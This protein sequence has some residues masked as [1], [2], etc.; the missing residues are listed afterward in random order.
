METLWHLY[1]MYRT[2][3][4]TL[5]QVPAELIWSERADVKPM[6]RG[7]VGVE[8]FEAHGVRSAWIFDP[9]QD[10]HGSYSGY[11]YKGVGNSDGSPMY[12]RPSG[13]YRIIVGGQ[14]F[15]WAEEEFTTNRALWDAGVACQRPIALFRLALE[16][17]ESSAG[18][19][20]RT[21]RSP[22]RLI[23][24][25]RQPGL[26]DRYLSITREDLQTYAGRLGGIIGR[27]LVRMFNAAMAKPVDIDNTSSEGELLDFEHVWNGWFW[28]SPLQPC[29]MFEA[30]YPIFREF[31]FSLASGTADFER[32]FVED[33]C[34]GESVAGNP[35]EKTRQ[36]IGRFLGLDLTDDQLL[37]PVNQEVRVK[38]LED[39]A[40]A[41]AFYRELETNRAAW[42][43]IAEGEFLFRNLD[44]LIQITEDDMDRMRRRA[45]KAVMP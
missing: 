16:G 42:T 18:L 10:S 26:L 2:G 29:Y 13:P 21:S 12:E 30:I 9:W 33:F 1:R 31:G 11:E 45:P 37:A 3:L 35:N 14:R 28:G 22:I 19:L 24:F 17:I 23:D 15:D 34:G 27:S 43:K 25:W 44:A 38:L 40:R 6:L 39:W 32:A 41:L 5:A 8:A 4:S 20:V 36:V 7:S